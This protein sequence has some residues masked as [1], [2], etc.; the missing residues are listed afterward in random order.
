MPA[1]G[2]AYSD[3]EIAALSNYVIDHFSG[4]HGS[5]TP[6]DVAKARQF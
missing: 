2:E 6:T 5:V 3:V 1:F 4:Q